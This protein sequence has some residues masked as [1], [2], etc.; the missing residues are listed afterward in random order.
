LTGRTLRICCAALFAFDSP[1]DPC[2]HWI[3][4][5]SLEENIDGETSLISTLLDLAT[6]PG[7]IANFVRAVHYGKTLGGDISHFGS[8]RVATH[9][10]FAYFPE[11]QWDVHRH[12]VGHQENIFNRRVEGDKNPAR[13]YVFF[14]QLAFPRGVLLSCRRESQ[15]QQQQQQESN[16]CKFR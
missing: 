11:F 13:P 10:H 1:S 3:A 8:Q 14:A 9:D 5:K 4:L 2:R 12:L 6:E 16:G 15:R 7:V